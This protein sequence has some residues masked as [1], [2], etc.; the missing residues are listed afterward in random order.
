MP[1][2]VSG[3][4]VIIP[5]QLAICFEGFLSH[6]PQIVPWE[7]CDFTVNDAHVTTSWDKKNRKFNLETESVGSQFLWMYWLSRPPDASRPPGYI[8]CFWSAFAGYFM[9]FFDT[10]RLSSKNQPSDHHYF[11][12]KNQFNPRVLLDY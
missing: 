1:L 11:C 6:R 3:I 10:P 7:T 8:N 4:G 5:V 12:S 9:R 2:D